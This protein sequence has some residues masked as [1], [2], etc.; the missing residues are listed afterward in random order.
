ML[1]SSKSTKKFVPNEFLYGQ[2]KHSR[3]NIKVR[4][5][6]LKTKIFAEKI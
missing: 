4:Q 2:E 5:T 1:S 6:F 3:R